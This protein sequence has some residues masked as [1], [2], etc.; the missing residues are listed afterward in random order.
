MA[1]TIDIP[2]VVVVVVVVVVIGQ[3]HFQQFF[4][5]PTVMVSYHCSVPQVVYAYLVNNLYCHQ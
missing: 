3:C 4:F 2:V 5:N 1:L